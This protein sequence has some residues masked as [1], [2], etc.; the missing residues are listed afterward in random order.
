LEDF[1][2][3]ANKLLPLAFY[4]NAKASINVNFKHTYLSSCSA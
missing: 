1:L 2:I 3:I 4:P